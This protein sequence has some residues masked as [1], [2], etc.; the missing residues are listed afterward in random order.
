MS[1]SNASLGCE[2]PESSV[3]GF[4]QLRNE[5]GSSIEML[6][7]ALRIEDLKAGCTPSPAG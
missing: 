4:S 2:K 6:S 1:K 5:L 7:P 3:P